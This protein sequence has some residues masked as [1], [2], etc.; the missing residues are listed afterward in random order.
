MASP[1]DALVLLPRATHRDFIW[2]ISW[3]V[4]KRE[5]QNWSPK[6]GRNQAAL[7]LTSIANPLQTSVFSSLR[8]EY[9]STGQL[10]IKKW[11]PCEHGWHLGDI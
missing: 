6:P 2:D 1:S 9:I 4:M 5:K 3:S 11:L 10:A 7:L 8:W